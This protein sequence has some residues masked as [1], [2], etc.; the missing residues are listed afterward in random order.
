MFHVLRSAPIVVLPL[1]HSS[2]RS[3][4]SC[5]WGCPRTLRA[6]RRE[7]SDEGSTPPA[8]R[9]PRGLHCSS[10]VRSQKF[11]S[12]EPGLHMYILHDFRRTN[13]AARRV[14]SSEFST[15]LAGG[16]G[17]ASASTASRSRA[18]RGGSSAPPILLRPSSACPRRAP[19]W[20]RRSPRTV[21]ASRGVSWF[22]RE[23]VACDGL[24]G[25]N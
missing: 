18:P 12:N 5:V 10:S 14:S 24:R 9:V 7:G 17:A 3:A 19:T 6:V 11:V 8:R 20:R 4:P 21:A 25:T 23:L 22:G 16:R 13:E 15:A 1:S 2:L